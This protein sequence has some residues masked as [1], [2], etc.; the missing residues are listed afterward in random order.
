M[1]KLSLESR[2]FREGVSSKMKNKKLFSVIL[3]KFCFPV[4]R[5]VKKKPCHAYFSIKFFFLPKQ[6]QKKKQS[7]FFDSSCSLLLIFTTNRIPTELTTKMKPL[8]K[9]KKVPVLSSLCLFSLCFFLLIDKRLQR[10]KKKDGKQR[11][12]ILTIC[13]SRTEKKTL[14]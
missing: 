6:W 7:L 12:K 2:F 14:N 11:P 8:Q 1:R 9:Q 3:C 10:G 5:Q 4:S 13:N